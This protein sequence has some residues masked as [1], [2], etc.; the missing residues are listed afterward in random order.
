MLE[1]EENNLNAFLDDSEGS[2]KDFIDDDDD[3]FLI[4]YEVTTKTV[5]LNNVLIELINILNNRNLPQKLKKCANLLINQ[6]R[7]SKM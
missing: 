3:E 6:N 5:T 1:Q 7:Y 2:L 4:D